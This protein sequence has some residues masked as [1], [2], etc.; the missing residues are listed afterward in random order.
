MFDVWQNGFSKSNTRR[1]KKLIVPANKGYMGIGKA[2]EKQYRLSYNKD[3]S[4]N[5]YRAY[6]MRRRSS[7]GSYSSYDSFSKEPSA[8]EIRASRLKSSS[9]KIKRRQKT[10]N[11]KKKVI[12]P[13]Q[14][15]WLYNIPERKYKL[16]Y[17]KGRYRAHRVNRRPSSSS[18]SSY[19]SIATQHS[20]LNGAEF[21]PSHMKTSSVHAK[22]KKSRYRSFNY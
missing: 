9:P 17:S 16:S 12:V 18:H 7:K 1:K 4:N 8:V 22:Q 20:N 3:Y 13:M 2:S 21:G 11:R 14:K 19:D 6:P 15:G 5:G 10:T